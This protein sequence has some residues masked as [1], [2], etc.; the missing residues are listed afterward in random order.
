MGKPPRVEAHGGYLRRR[1]LWKTSMGLWNVL[2][3][4]AQNSS[5]EICR[6]ASFKSLTLMYTFTCA[7]AG[8]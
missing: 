3:S 8:T 2:L 4:V 7:F 5:E 6:S 1:M